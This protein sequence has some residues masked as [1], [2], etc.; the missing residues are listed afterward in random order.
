MKL[1]YY[2]DEVFPDSYPGRILRGLRTREGLTQVQLAEKAALKPHHV[3][4]ME[5]GKRPIRKVMARRLA[6][7][8]NSSYQIIL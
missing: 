5:N 2:T 6:K 7:V 4:E 3:S 1:L 8:L